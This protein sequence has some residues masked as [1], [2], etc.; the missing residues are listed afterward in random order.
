MLSVS[1]IKVKLFTILSM[2]CMG[3]FSRLVLGFPLL[4]PTST[5]TVHT[6]PQETPFPTNGGRT[7]LRFLPTPRYG[8]KRRR[9]LKNKVIEE[10]L[11]VFISDHLDANFDFMGEV[12]EPEKRSACEF[13][14]I[15]Y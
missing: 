14:H 9:I 6:I 13:G 3:L 15:R 10:E 2:V 8:Q 12:I 7:S 5:S 4:F 11:T 1:L